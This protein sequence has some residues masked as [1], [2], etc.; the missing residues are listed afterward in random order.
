M[1][2]TGAMLIEATERLLADTLDDAAMRR[3]RG[4]EWL[5]VAWD[6][7]E[8]QGLPLALVSEDKG[9]FGIDAIDA[10]AL[11]RLTGRYAVPLPIAET[12]IA[13]AALA[14]AG[15]E[16]P[17]GPAALVSDASR[18]PW[19]RNLAVLVVDAG[20]GRIARHNQGCKVT[21][22][23]VNLAH[24]PRD[25]LSLADA[26][27]IAALP[28]LS[29]KARG[30]AMRALQV[31]GALDRVLEL[32]V[33]H[34]SERVQFGRPLSKF[35]AIQQELARL[36]GEVAAASAAADLAAE[37]LAGLANDPLLAIAAARVRQGEAVGKAVAIAQQ[38]HGAIGFTEE[39]RL[40]WFTTALWSWRDEYGGQRE[41][42]RVVA[43]RAFDA[44]YDGYWPMVAGV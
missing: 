26:P 21:A 22:E 43:S 6:A 18:V 14:E 25:T 44:D 35:Q 4:G 11:I 42:S 17:E 19:G 8:A 39:H 31:A 13:Y 3:A 33:G 29:V 23:Q 20:D 12:M 16:L 41:W 2:D 37:A 38:L 9:G 32:T 5:A 40:H 7:V 27:Q 1:D 10:L 24:M 28:G 30:A 36:A 15:L 34:V